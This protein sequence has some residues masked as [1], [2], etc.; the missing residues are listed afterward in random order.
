[1]DNFTSLRPVVQEFPLTHC[2]LVMLYGI[3]VLHQHQFRQW[4]GTY[5]VPSHCLN[6]CWF[7]FNQTPGT[8]ITEVW[9]KLQ[10]E[11]KQK[12]NFHYVSPPFCA[13][14]DPETARLC[15]NACPIPASFLWQVHKTMIISWWPQSYHMIIKGSNFTGHSTVCSQAYPVN[16][17]TRPKLY[18]TSSLCKESISNEWIPPQR[19]SNMEMVSISWCYHIKEDSTI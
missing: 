8:N 11:E 7:I 2:G 9:S 18:I 17:K 6:Q 13:R 3:V 19:A 16:Y 5:L 1:M 15:A 14:T 4:L 12:K 10:E